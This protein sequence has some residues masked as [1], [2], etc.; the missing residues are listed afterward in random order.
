MRP[1]GCLI[2]H[3]DQTDIY[4]NPLH[5][6]LRRSFEDM[7]DVERFTQFLHALVRRSVWHHRCSTNDAQPFTTEAPQGGDYLS[8]DSIVKKLLLGSAAKTLERQY[9]ND[10]SL[11]P[12]PSCC[13]RRG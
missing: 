12:A 3:T 6:H 11:L 8:D 9:G 1:N 10:C 2:L 7:S 4:S 13:R 5:F